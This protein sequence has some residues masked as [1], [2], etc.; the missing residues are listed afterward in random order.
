MTYLN[1]I[2]IIF[3]DKLLNNE[4]L[5]IYFTFQLYILV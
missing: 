1:Y 4:I 2:Y 5:F 3:K